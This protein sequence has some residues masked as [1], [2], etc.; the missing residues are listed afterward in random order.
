MKKKNMGKVCA[1]VIVI[2][3]LLLVVFSIFYFKK[4]EIPAPLF[5]EGIVFG[6]YT[7]LFLGE[8]ENVLVIPSSADKSTSYKFCTSF[9]NSYDAV[10]LQGVGESAEKYAYDMVTT[11]KVDTLYV[12]KDASRDFLKKV[13][14]KC[15]DMDVVTLSANRHFVA[16]DMLLSVGKSSKESVA[17]V[18]THGENTFLYATEQYKR[19]GNFTY[20]IMPSDAL[21]GSEKIACEYGFM[22]DGADKLLLM[23]RAT[24]LVPFSVD[25]FVEFM[26]DGAGESAFGF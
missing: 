14:K 3:A 12:H 2:F 21:A 4:P 16:S 13:R 20:A 9:A 25:S 17:L 22:A 7:T 10:I 1:G 19:N 5:T 23:N 24:N 18:F 15:P 8:E 26:D 6:D 11:Y